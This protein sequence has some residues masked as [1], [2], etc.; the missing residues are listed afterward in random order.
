MLFLRFLLSVLFFSTAFGKKYSEAD[1][2]LINSCKTSFEEEIDSYIKKNTDYQK[3]LEKTGLQNSNAANK[4]LMIFF[5]ET[6]SNPYLPEV[7]FYK[8]CKQDFDSLRRKYN[9]LNF[10]IEY[11]IEDSKKN[12]EINFWITFFRTKSLV[13]F[14]QSKNTKLKEIYE[15]TIT[16]VSDI[17]K[18]KPK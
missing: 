9:D 5:S 4:A 12:K 10:A 15:T 1:C 2:A 3:L 11:T 17:R 7:E 8:N 14:N 6:Y 18:N 16:K 13:L